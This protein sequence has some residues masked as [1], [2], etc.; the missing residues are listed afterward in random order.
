MG[1]FRIQLEEALLTHGVRTCWI[2]VAD[3]TLPSAA[4]DRLIEPYLGGNDP[5]FGF[6]YPGELA[7]FFDK[8]GLQGL[9]PDPH[10]EL[11]ILYGCG[12]ALAGW[13]GLLLY[14]DVP[15]NEIQFRAASQGG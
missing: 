9:L 10:A 4:V 7:G 5:L 3:A 13:E 14:I 15:K 1:F 6:R 12:A 2:P 8:T 11:N